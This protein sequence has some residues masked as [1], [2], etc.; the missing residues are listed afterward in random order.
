MFLGIGESFNTTSQVSNFVLKPAE[1]ELN[2]PE[3]LRLSVSLSRHPLDS[4]D[5][6]PQKLVKSWEISHHQPHM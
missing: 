6:F 2:I 3:S 4:G 5:G 1:G